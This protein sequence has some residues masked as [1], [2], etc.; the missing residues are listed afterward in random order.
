MKKNHKTLSVIVMVWLFLLIFLAANVRPAT[1]I[2]YGQLDSTNHYPN[3]GTLVVTIPGEGDFPV[4]SGTLIGE[5]AFLTAGHC[6]NFLSQAIAAGDLVIENIKVSFDPLNSTTPASDWD[7]QKLMTHPDFKSVTAFVIADVGMVTLVNK[8]GIAPAQLAPVG[9]LDGLQASGQ[10]Q[11]AAPSASFTLVG[12]GAQLNWPPPQLNFDSTGRYYTDAVF[13]SLSSRWIHV[14]QNPVVGNGGICF[15]DSGGPTFWKTQ[16]GQMLLAGVNSWV[17]AIH[18]N[19]NGYS[20]RVDLP[21]IQS[22]I[23]A[24]TH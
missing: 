24:A 7:V 5:R 12:Y 14:N 2:T 22:F 23:Y 11:K 15:G 3:V 1:A 16:S 10:L 9:Y 8:P 21:E 6:T 20:Y 17:G 18:C 4:C 19:S 13:Q